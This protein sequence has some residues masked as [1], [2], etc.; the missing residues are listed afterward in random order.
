MRE[1][2][3]KEREGGFVQVMHLMKNKQQK[4]RFYRV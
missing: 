1:D 4:A 2:V 3:A